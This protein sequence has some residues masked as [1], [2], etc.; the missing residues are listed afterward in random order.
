MHILVISKAVTQTILWVD[1]LHDTCISE[2]PC[3]LSKNSACHTLHTLGVGA[4]TSLIHAVLEPSG[5]AT[6]LHGQSNCAVSDITILNC[7][8]ILI[9]IWISDYWS[10][11]WD[12]HVMFSLCRYKVTA[13]VHSLL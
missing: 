9:H 7:L 10:V 13:K 3:K 6:V 12:K 4:T 2:W 5:G 11:I 1:L 8:C